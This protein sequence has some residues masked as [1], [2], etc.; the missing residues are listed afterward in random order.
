[1]NL[2]A[3]SPH[4]L[5]TPGTGGV[6]PPDLASKA[7][8]CDK[9]LAEAREF[10]RGGQFGG[11]P[12]QLVARAI[13]LLDDMDE[14]LITL[15]PAGNQRSFAIAATLHRELALVQAALP[16]Q[17]RRHGFPPPETLWDAQQAGSGNAKER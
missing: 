1:M 2:T 12:D 9:V 3:T 14:I 17:R 5:R 11:L 15:D 6:M 16:N 10:S 7:D 4:R 13:E 8:I